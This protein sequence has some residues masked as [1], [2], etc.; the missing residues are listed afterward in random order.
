M[1]TRRRG[2]GLIPA[3]VAAGAV[4]LLVI[5]AF[6]ACG[7]DAEEPV[8]E[9]PEPVE[10]PAE[11]PE[12]AP[13]D[14]EAC[15]PEEPTSDSAGWQEHSAAGF[16]FS[17]PPEWEDLSGVVSL[18]PATLVAPETF[19]ETGM[20]DDDRIE[21]DFVRDPA[22]FPN[23]SVMRLDGVTS[24]VEVVYEREEARYGGLAEVQEIL[25]TRIPTCVAGEEGVGLD[26]H[27]AANGDDLVYQKN[28]YVVRNGALYILQVLGDDQAAHSPLLDEV[29]RTWHWT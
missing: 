17:R 15:V 3:R 22:G 10:E 4:A 8:A 13:V 5:V 26:F 25:T 12:E 27:S 28:Y 24:P 6:A 16:S 9:T 2:Y 29:V 19:Q 1:R 18:N 14:A 23:L 20:G 11:P 7:D 21:A